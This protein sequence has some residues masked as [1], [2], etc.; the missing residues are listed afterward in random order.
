MYRYSEK[1]VTVINDMMEDMEK[2]GITEK[3][4]STWFSTIILINKL[5]G[6][7]KMCLHYRKVN[8][9]LAIDIYPLSRLDELVEHATGN[10]Y[11]TTLYL[12][13]LIS[14]GN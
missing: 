8:T 2:Q 1:A 14:G 7:K 12:R 10:Q 13:K 3:P 4:T 6:T 5:D 11:Y 9:N